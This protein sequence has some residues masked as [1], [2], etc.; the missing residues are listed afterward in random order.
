M[1]H[2]KW[3]P[4]PTCQTT[5][6]LELIRCNPISDM[7][8]ENM[9]AC[10]KIKITVPGIMGTPKA[11][12][13]DILRL[14][15]KFG[16][17]VKKSGSDCVVTCRNNNF[18]LIC[19]VNNQ[20][21][22]DCESPTPSLCPELR[23]AKLVNCSRIQGVTCKIRCPNGKIAY[24]ETFCLPSYEWSPLP[25]CDFRSQCKKQKLPEKLHFINR[26]CKSSKVRYCK[27]GCNVRV[28][29]PT[30]LRTSQEVVF[31]KDIYCASSGEWKGLP[32]CERAERL[33]W[34]KRIKKWLCA[35]P[36]LG[37]YSKLQG[38]CS[39]LEGSICR[40]KCKKGFFSK[41][42]YT[43]RCLKRKWHGIHKC[44]P[45]SCPKLPDIYELKNNC[46][47][48]S[49]SIC[50]ALCRAGE[51]IGKSMIFCYPSG[52]WS[53]LP[54]CVP[55]RTCPRKLS[56][57][58]AF[59][60]KCTFKEG[61]KCQVRCR[62][63]LVLVGSNFVICRR[64]K[65]RDAPGCFLANETPYKP[66]EFKCHFPLQLNGNL[67]IIGFCKPL[68][69]M[70]CDI[71]CRD[72]SAHMTGPNA[73]TCLPPGLWTFLRPCTGGK[74]YC[75][76]PKFRHVVMM[77]YC[78]GKEVGLSCQGRCK[79]RPD[80][81]FSIKCT[82]DVKWS[83]PPICTCP[84][85]I[86][87]KGIEFKEKCD[88]KQM[89][90]K[91]NVKC[92]SGFIMVGAGL[93]ICNARLQWSKLP[94]C[95]KIVCPK[96]KLT[97]VLM[98]TKDCT[99]IQMGKS[100]HL[101]CKE[102]GA[103][104]PHSKINCINGKHWT[105]LPFCACPPPSL[106]EGM[107]T[108]NGCNKTI[109]G[110]K[111]FISCTG[112]LFL[113]GKNYIICQKNTR[114][115][116]AP[117]CKKKFCHKP[118][119]TDTLI[120]DE[121]C[122]SKQ[123]GERCLMVCK[124]LGSLVGPTFIICSNATRWSPLPR[125][126]CPP[127]SL[128]DFL[129]AKEDCRRKLPGESCPLS[130]TDNLKV[131]GNAT[132]KCRADAHWSP[133]PKCK[134]NY[135]IK[136]QLPRTLVHS[137]DCT[138]IPPGKKCFVE[139]SEGGEVEGNN[140]ITCIGGSQWTALPRCRCP[141]PKLSYYLNATNDCSRKRIGENCNLQCKERR[142]V[143]GK[144]FI[145]CQNNTLWSPLPKCIQNFCLKL[146]LPAFLIYP[147]DCSTKSPGE[148]CKLE[149]TEGGEF[150][151]S[152]NITCINGKKWS[153]L[154]KCT[155]PPPNLNERLILTENC[156][157]K[158]IGQKCFLK[159]TEH[160]SFSG[161][162]F[163]K[164]QNNTR[165]SPLPRCVIN[166]C[167]LPKL[168]KELIFAEDCASKVTGES[169]LLQ[170]A[171]AGELIGSNK[172]T[173]INI[174]KW[175]PFPKCT[176]P[177]PF[178]EESLLTIENCNKKLIGE[179]CRVKC[180]ESFKLLGSDFITCQEN[181][182]WSSSPRCNILTCVTPKLNSILSFHE[183]CASKSLN[184]TCE[185][186]CKEGGEIIGSKYITCKKRGLTLFWTD[187]PKCTCADPSILDELKLLEKCHAKR[188]GESCK[189]NCTDK[190]TILGGNLIH[191]Q[192]NTK[193]S[194]L[195][196]CVLNICMKPKLPQILG[197]LE[198][199][200]SKYVG[201]SCRL[202]CH[203]FGKLLNVSHIS[204]L[205]SRSWSPY[206]ICTCPPMTVLPISLSDNVKF[207]E[208][209]SA[210][211]PGETCRI[212]C[213]S[214]NFKMIR[215][216]PF[217]C[218]NDSTWNFQP[219]CRKV[220]CS[221]LILPVYLEFEKECSNLSIGSVC[222]VK[223]AQNG[224]LI[225]EKLL[226][227]LN[228]STWSKFPDCTCSKPVF[229][230]ALQN[231]QNCDHI[232][233]GEKCFIKCTGGLKINGNDF[234]LCKNNMKWSLLPR[235]VQTL[236]PAPVFNGSLFTL[237]EDCSKKTVADKC[238]LACAQ[239]GIIIG[240]KYIECR[241]NLQWTTNM[242]DCTCRIP[243]I[244]DPFQLV[245][246]CSFKKRG[247]NCR[248][249]CKEGYKLIGQSN[250]VCQNT[251]KPEWT[252][253]PTCKTIE[254][255]IPIITNPALSFKTNCM[256]RTHGTVCYLI[257][258]HDGQ[259]L[260][261]DFIKCEMTGAWTSFPDC[262]CS[263]P[264]FSNGLKA[265]QN[266]TSIKKGEKCLVECEE[267][268]RLVGNNSISC[269]NNL[270]WSQPPSCD[271]Q[272][273]PRPVIPSALSTVGGNCSDTIL[274][275]DCQVSC[276]FGGTLTGSSRVKCLSNGTWSSFPDCTCTTPTLTSN[277]VFKENCT[278]K[279]RNEKCAVACKRGSTHTAIQYITCENYTRWSALPTCGKA[280]CPP[281]ILSILKT[282]E[283][284]SQKS[285][286]EVC[287]VSCKENG[288]LI[289]KK[290]LKC[291]RK[292]RWSALPDC[293]CAS[294]L[295]TADLKIKQNC[296]FT[297]RG[298]KC[299]LHCKNDTLKLQGNDYILCQNNT[300][301]ST[302]PKCNV[303][304]PLHC[305]P[306]DLGGGILLT[307]EDC[308]KK[309][310][311]DE[312]EV[313]CRHGGII[314]GHNRLK[315]SSNKT[316]SSLPD[317]TCPSP[318]LKP[319][320]ELQGQCNLKKRNEKCV[321]MCVNGS[322]TQQNNFLKY[323]ICQNNSKWSEMPVCE[324]KLCKIPISP[325]IGFN[326]SCLS[327]DS[328]LF[329]SGICDVHCLE[330]GTL[331]GKKQVRC[332][333]N[334]TWTEL[335]DCACPPPVL[336]KHIEAL[337]DCSFTRRGGM[338]YLFCNSIASQNYFI[339]CQNNT[340]WSRLPSCKAQC[341]RPRS[342]IRNI[343]W[344]SISDCMN[345]EV[346]EKCFLECTFGGKFI[347]DRDFIT[348]ISA[349]YWTE[350]PECTCSESFFDYIVEEDCSNKRRN[351]TCKVACPN[352]PDI[353][354]LVFCDEHSSWRGFPTCYLDICS[355]PKLDFKKF[356]F[357]KESGDCSNKRIQESCYVYCKN[358]GKVMM[359]D[360]LKNDIICQKN[361]W[362][363]DNM[364]CTCPSFIA[365]G[366]ME[367]RSSYCK[368]AE[369][370]YS[371]PAYC[372]IGNN[373]LISFVYCE[374]N[375]TW[376][377]VPECS[378]Y[379]KD[380]KLMAGKKYEIL[381]DCIFSSVGHSCPL[382]CKTGKTNERYFI[383]CLSDL[384][385]T[386][387]P[388]CPC[389]DPLLSANV[390]LLEDCSRKFPHEF[391]LITCEGGLVISR[392]FL[393]CQ[394]DG[395]W[396][397]TPT[398]GSSFCPLPFIPEEILEF[399]SDCTKKKVGEICVFKCKAG[400][401]I[402]ATS[403]MCLGDF[404]WTQFPKCTCP[405]PI[406]NR[407]L[408]TQD[409]CN[410][411]YPN[412]KC[413]I[414]C[415]NGYA[416]QKNY[417]TC[418][419]NSRWE[420][421]PSCVTFVCPTP[422]LPEK[423]LRILEDCNTK[424][425]GETC[426]LHC[427]QGGNILGSDSIMCSKGYIWSQLPSC[428]CPIPILNEH[429]EMQEDCSRKN[430]LEHCS[431]RCLNGYALS[432]HY[433]ICKE[434]TQWEPLPSCGSI[435]CP[436]LILPEGL[437]EFLE[438]CNAKG[439]GESC[440]LRCTHGGNILGNQNVI[441][442]GDLR[443]TPL[444][445]CSCP[446]LT[447]NDDLE[448]LEDCS[449]KSLNERCFIRC[450]NGFE[451]PKDHITCQEIAKW[452]YLPSC[453]TLVCTSPIL[454][455]G[456]ISTSED[457]SVKKVGDVC[458][459]RCTQGGNILGSNSI[460]CSEG[461]IWS[462]LPTCTCPLPILNE[463]L[464][465][466]EDCSRKNALEYCSIRCLNGYVLQK[467]YII[468]Q[469]NTQWEPLPSCVS[470]VCPLPI[471]PEGVLAF[472]EDCNAKKPGESCRL[473]CIQSGSIIEFES[474]ICSADL[475][476]TPLPPCSCPPLTVNEELDLLEDCS[477]KRPN[478]RCFIRC[479]NSFA[480]NKD[481][482]ICQENAQWE[483]QPTC[484]YIVCQPPILP[485]GFLAFL[486]DCNAKRPGE[487]C[488]LRCMQGGNIMGSD[489]IICSD[490]LTWSQL[491]ACSCPLPILNEYLEM[492]EDCSRKSALEYC[493]IRCLNG[494]VLPKHYIICQENT[495]WEPLPSCV[496]LV[497]PPPILPEGFLAFLE[498]CNAKRPG[499]SCQLRC[500]QGGNILGS[501][502]IMCSDVLTWSQLP[503]CSCPLPIL[504]E[505][506]EMQEDC[507][508]KSA[509]EYCSI[510][511]LNGYVLPKHYII[512]QENTQWEPLPSCVSLV[513]PPPIL[514]ESFLAFLEDCNAKRPGES[515]QLRC[516]QGGSILGSDSIIC[517]TDLRWSEL[518]SCTCSVPV[519]PPSFQFR[520]DCSWKRPGESCQVICGNL[521]HSVECSWNGQ[522]SQFVRCPVY[523]AQDDDVAG[524]YY[525][526]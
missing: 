14:F 438:D 287:R 420:A 84:T 3:S 201:E 507:S 491:P 226:K 184:E 417:I 359:N 312:C 152:S 437:L 110:Q 510:R 286:E 387:F 91:C 481:H 136:K 246:N 38:R 79:H 489:R 82:S 192:N 127:P 24:E 170:C 9:A 105:K 292:L 248:I 445:S 263:P 446:P 403:I 442:L 210:K 260:G 464:E 101:E 217:M 402:D 215:P 346:G 153:P 383:F 262:A 494:Y 28:F 397:S 59:V 406:F 154:P 372:I 526:G 523:N 92:K 284:C 228:D 241:K 492:Q 449:F 187:F 268:F 473:N 353:K 224:Q 460:I 144:N 320:S 350:E 435:V 123:P 424:K 80:I 384:S 112:K 32:N 114:W 34:N 58:I 198:D 173:C 275:G 89:G 342:D 517:S 145:I 183:D 74:S 122:S 130:C 147:E 338:C 216:E 180:K 280:T 329:A 482:I 381:A 186:E 55:P 407:F 13:P 290:H 140:F 90:Q 30:S 245:G 233:R 335:P 355:V 400:G 490:V 462:Q 434:N 236:C 364:T 87:R 159:C 99:A 455:T 502:S 419:D 119:L 111:C 396:D 376:S 108:K 265:K 321:V 172:I 281:P 53:P 23:Y 163:T 368:Y 197:F 251:L 477:F 132:I 516:M 240:N 282:D 6:T 378:K 340:K 62:G 331:I 487:S 315:C 470:L 261:N 41:G 247:E 166:F 272:T 379:C 97:S 191:C 206:P 511:C 447:L 390:K 26:T 139:C 117:L 243:K 212:N 461:Y 204:C 505:H 498:D 298:E 377:E 93:I 258:K 317:C 71:G 323:I 76:A 476:W 318:K 328:K 199:C 100:C 182:R 193:W 301:W 259:I 373:T 125:C 65:W 249:T 308:S 250:I 174:T 134:E 279:R 63:T 322:K 497:C 274:G 522:W 303:Q 103:I 294:P 178:L 57:Q 296:S 520:E 146:K 194:Y 356:G 29:K 388:E 95:K 40:Y 454:P 200:S 375:G 334:L 514:P 141:A 412:E 116:K 189:V 214:P 42:N 506:L 69:G 225:G 351:E 235:C 50:E 415:K 305:S 436:P 160:F 264:T 326:R 343:I 176:C 314:L 21:P 133:L 138:A 81:K 366:E 411:K 503:A 195:P 227:C 316:W 443:W 188:P 8:Q 285:V 83:I 409:D 349:H 155:C 418:Q 518:P 508:R 106:D 270:K 151:G 18:I 75:S 276:L 309:V 17:C 68:G 463:Y 512:C 325:V 73:T 12:C 126:S 22:G 48:V 278:F 61:E 389:P 371:C 96:P 85:P 394:E 255:S 474:I 118:I 307:K 56:P 16:S 20:L 468:C 416:L 431:I 452:E 456:V 244:S 237:K 430:P 496:S 67:K 414:S 427:I 337:H 357:L 7:S 43:I 222:P 175:E 291:L 104:L 252:P 253:L 521:Q 391:C 203:N 143:V 229:S 348:C 339:T 471:L 425:I 135:C 385:W 231:T 484:V 300:K 168:P 475:T 19:L 267:K 306:P 208:N 345:V 369:I 365:S 519:L 485:E 221:K 380:P 382:R 239:G 156:S 10:V 341:S 211:L 131:E 304:I 254:C 347:G 311:G 98:F 524:M 15:V 421:L 392:H 169:C 45:V 148:Q 459:L 213:T 113:F 64:G 72:H 121:D 283:D 179:K 469:E 404:I 450:K 408:E 525:N 426:R 52:H 367:L 289:G 51:L 196:K 483:P 493:S 361:G 149:C 393:I 230:T 344:H 440:Q 266:C 66:F 488:Q 422:T 164:C 398:C 232:K 453:F 288:K 271:K 88:T 386:A 395:S 124:N 5:H 479:K 428:T 297:K 486:E 234:I 2:G 47:H 1:S 441:C 332:T 513:C 273:C 86:L 109:P 102:G 223:C 358:G 515:C 218:R 36:K 352:T 219:S 501:D 242:P 49:G 70:S 374:N 158:L 432:K 165:W 472:L 205:K 324:K 293:S 444:P 128:P 257:C 448:I 330:N 190:L 410:K 202:K 302:L 509:L 171:R 336:P 429:L 360:R 54:L 362:T 209:C 495:Q 439:S 423:V 363:I 467:H 94:L 413:F 37:K 11:V 499:E 401:S 354:E 185:L 299:F 181:S 137:T 313:Y 277:V 451:L 319:N 310:I 35:K 177:A 370:G 457:C 115:S 480:L 433:I 399:Q 120:F 150:I 107:G 142:K 4:L 39:Y 44:E 405:P 478:E 327:G 33:F 238:E 256:N 161:R 31:I 333:K 25:A 458:Q 157:R 46:P 60:S 167:I 220:S 465:M 129:K 78:S 162:N 27:V 77:E 207:L 466:Q 295:L 269:Q 500:M 504:N